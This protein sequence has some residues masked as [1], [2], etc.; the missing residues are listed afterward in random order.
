M[1]RFHVWRSGLFLVFVFTVI[2]VQISL[3][4]FLSS[5]DQRSEDVLANK[6][7]IIKRE[8]DVVRRLYTERLTATHRTI[9]ALKVRLNQASAEDDR[10][11][12]S[13]EIEIL[14]K[15]NAE[16]SS[17]LAKYKK[18]R[19]I[20]SAQELSRLK[21]DATKLDFLKSET[22]YN[23]FSIT[24]FDSFTHVGIYSVN[25]DGLVTRP[26]KRPI[27][28]R[29]KEHEEILNF[30]LRVL[31]DE[32]PGA[33]NIEKRDL[34]NGISRL[35][36]VTGTQYDLIFKAGKPNQ[37]HRVKIRRPFSHLELVDEVE[38]LDTSK[39]LI[40][41]IIPLSGRT[42]SF[43]VFLR[44]F[45]DICIRWDGKVYLTVVY[46]GQKGYQETKNL[47]AEFEKR[48]KFKNYKFIYN[49]GPFSRGVG[50][51]QGA[52]AW[53]K[54]NN[55][56][57]FCDVDMHFTAD[58]L[59]RCR[60]YTEPGRMVYYPIV[61]SLYNPEIVF[62]G[63][64]PAIDRQ[65]YVGKYNGF[66]RD[67]G[68][69]MTCVYKNDFV[70]TRGFDTTIHGWGMED[71]KLYRKFLRTKLAVIRATDRGIFH[72]YHPKRC[73]S[74]LPSEQYLSCL[75]SK[76]SN[77]ASHR[78]MGMLAFGN[79]LFS[80]LSPDWK[81]KL[82]YQPDFT[83]RDSKT[84]SKKAI[85]LWK[86]ADDLD[87]EILEIKQLQKRLEYAMNFTTFGR[88]IFNQ[89]TVDV[90]V[91]RDLRLGLENTTQVIKKIALSLGKNNSRINDK[92][93]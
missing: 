40:N 75:H 81:T 28:A 91:L 9:A 45:G 53:E 18:L 13:T 37:Y 88:N 19:K 64:P 1:P 76:A 83:M 23:E 78:Q 32:L 71:I 89:N 93:Q 68:F 34:A 22:P 48:E 11:E 16:L 77:E 6:R 90:R 2:I 69:G 47:L 8:T 46:F 80:N 55:I 29:V 41:L 85:D 87:I 38:T 52:L 14:R 27:G 15:V 50:L 56:M 12:N 51:Q 7:N 3:N 20:V 82:E 33:R 42:D 44:H 67:F 72:M 17:K 30:A 39:E 59:E 5:C 92:F 62:N 10:R 4:L 43:K 54:G 73:D 70:A 63:K 26:A 31:R 35:S 58:F 84:K 36:R 86:R 74:S 21:S 24:P 79:R 25:K 57:F 65:L 61:F 49:D 60:F 66:W